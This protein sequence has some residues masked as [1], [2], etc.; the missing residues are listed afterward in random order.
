MASSKPRHFASDTYAPI[1]PQ[2]WAAM[3]AVNRDHAVAYGDDQ[4]TAKSVAAVRAFLD[5]PTCEVFFVSSGTVGN[6]LALASMVQPFQSVGS[7]LIRPPAPWKPL[8]TS[9][10]LVTH[11]VSHVNV[12][13]CGAPEFYTGGSKLLP[14]TGPNGKITP[15]GLDRVASAR[16]GDVHFPQVGAVVLTQ[17]TEMGTV[18]SLDELNALVT[19]AKSHRVRVLMDGARFCNALATLNCT[20]AEMTWKVRQ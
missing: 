20:P 1:C 11:D 9:C 4:H 14:T 13:E 5:A 10:L 3:E 7:L 19:T 2:A 17:A 16:K 6:A 8:L 18:Y 12:D 15:E